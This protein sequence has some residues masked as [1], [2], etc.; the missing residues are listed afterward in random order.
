RLQ[1]ARLDLHAAALARQH[2]LAP[3]TLGTS[4][5]AERPQHDHSLRLGA[6]AAAQQ[7]APRRWPPLPGEPELQEPEQA[8]G[9]GCNVCVLS[10]ATFLRGH[11]AGFGPGATSTSIYRSQD[12]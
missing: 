2:L 7:V 4:G 10:A 11:A 9:D 12:V 1:R 3:G 8:V 6:G 5:G